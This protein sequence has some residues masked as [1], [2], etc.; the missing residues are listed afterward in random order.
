MTERISEL[1]LTS[2]QLKII[3][4]L[5]M[6]I[7]HIGIVFFPQYGIFRIIGRLSFPIFCFLIVEG[8]FHTSDIMGYM[9]RLLLFALVSEIPYD[10]LFFGS[11]FDLTRQNVFFTLVLGVLLLYLLEALQG[12]FAK[13]SSVIFIML[14]AEALKSDYSSMGILI[15]LFFYSYHQR[16]TMRNLSVAIMNIRAM[17]GVQ[18]Y[19]ALS[20]IPISFYK[21]NRGFARQRFFYIIYPA[22]LLVLLGMKLLV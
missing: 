20:L 12:D 11:I 15:I 17:G 1:E 4:I 22:S 3:G 14:L 9:R 19:G 8:F 6:L 13:T 16:P 10:L 2:F 18:V 21:G 7:D 5:T